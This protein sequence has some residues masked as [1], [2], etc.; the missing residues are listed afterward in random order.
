MT[1][2]YALLFNA[3]SATIEDVQVS[4]ADL[5]LSE[6]SAKKLI[7]KGTADGLCSGLEV[8]LITTSGMEARL[9]RMQEILIL[10]QQKAEA[11]YLEGTD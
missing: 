10:T 9:Q 4:L 8:L 6:S 3:V 7:S 2:E 5:I 11:L 1:K